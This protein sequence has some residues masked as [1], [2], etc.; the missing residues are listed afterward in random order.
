MDVFIEISLIL[1]LATVVA[2]VM[3]LLRQPL[4]I[5]H[6]ISGLLV[7]PAVFDLVSATETVEL[8]SHIGIALLLFIIGLG[9]N[10]RIIR[11]VGKIA[12]MTGVGQILFT[13]SIGFL[14]ATALGFE[15]TSALYIGA[16]LAFSSTIIILKL[17]S[18]KKDTHRLYG[19]VATGFLLVQDIVAV[20]VLIAVTSM[21]QNQSVVEVLIQTFGVG[22]VFMAAIAFISHYVFP[23]L[24]DFL[25]RSQE[26]LFLF[27][28][29]WGFS[30]AALAQYIGFSVEIGALAA[31]VAL[32]GS[33]YAPEISSR[34]RPLRDFFIVLFFIVLGAELDIA[35]IGSGLLPAIAL[36]IFILVGNPIIVMTIMG[37]LKFTRKTSF[38]AGLTVAQIS[39]FSLIL[40]LLGR[41][42]GHI[43]ASIVSIITL[44]AMI[45]IAASTY[46]IM[47]SDKLY[48]YLSPYLKIFERKNARSAREAKDEY[49]IIL[50]GFKSG[51]RGLIDGFEKLGKRYLVVDY[52]PEVIDFLTDDGVPCLFGDANDTELLEE[53]PVEKTKVAIISA[54]D[55]G[56]NIIVIGHIRQRNPEAVIIAKAEEAYEAQELYDV[57]ADYVMMPHFLS[58]Q[59][60]SKK[61]LRHGL[62]VGSHFDRARKQH[63]DYLRKNYK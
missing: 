27:S 15:L 59:E 21:G 5:G 4:I 23:R 36:S 30:M 60:I 13:S 43:D 51:S 42:V 10:P 45:T 26:F 33:P 6:I 53:L 38:K 56:A 24:G 1:G 54:T 34:M 31:G 8:F 63:L 55:Y 19:K 17:L 3:H 25:A 20:L 29:G 35:N 46:M 44:V 47:Y 52:D 62:D 39:E 14:I 48:E 9:L 61:I 50:F 57:G 18:D 40:L 58:A 28:V 16:G 49:D 11:E 41:D 32:A 12:V 22:I 37:W 7:G 2:A